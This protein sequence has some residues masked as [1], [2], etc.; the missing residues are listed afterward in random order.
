MIPRLRS[1]FS[2][3]FACASHCFSSSRK[4]RWRCGSLLLRAIS[5]HSRASC[6]SRSVREFIYRPPASL[7]GNFGTKQPGIE[8]IQ[9]NLRASAELLRD[10]I[11]NSVLGQKRTRQ[12]P[13][14]AKRDI[15]QC[16]KNRFTRDRPE[17][18]PSA[19]PL[20][21]YPAP[22][23]YCHATPKTLNPLPVRVVMPVLAL[24]LI[25]L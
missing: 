13:L 25:E 24:N 16:S 11:A 3:F 5:A 17:S 2:S 8:L 10:A 23:R 21:Q 9:I 20:P 7:N 1:F 15:S 14:C 12:R 4:E 18:R 6:R 19:N 22:Q